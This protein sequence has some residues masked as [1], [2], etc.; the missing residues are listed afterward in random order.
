LTLEILIQDAE[1]TDG[2]GG[3][4]LDNTTVIDAVPPKFD[5][6]MINAVAVTGKPLQRWK[7]SKVPTINFELIVL[8]TGTS[9]LTGASL[10]LTDLDILRKAEAGY[11]GVD[12][13]GL[14]VWIRDTTGDYFIRHWK[15]GHVRNLDIK[16]I[17]GFQNEVG[18]TLYRVTFNFDVSFMDGDA[19][20]QLVRW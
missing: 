18:S 13:K 20:H 12:T 5:G 9:G 7:G 3:T 17:Q 15:G 6:I 4:S 14:L 10:G 8:E 11:D 1:P 19:H 2:T 16:R